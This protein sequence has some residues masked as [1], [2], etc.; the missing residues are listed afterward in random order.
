LQRICQYLVF[1]IG[2]AILALPVTASEY[3]ISVEYREQIASAAT[4]AGEMQSCRLPWDSFF[5][6]YMRGQREAAQQED[7]PSKKIQFVATFFG[8]VQQQ[9]FTKLGVRTCADSEVIELADRA[10]DILLADGA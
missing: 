10:A 5:L 9:T 8:A 1:C 4:V 7:W 3:E 2:A 6:A